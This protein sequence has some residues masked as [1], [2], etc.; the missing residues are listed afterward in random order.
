MLFLK[1]TGTRGTRLP[2]IR[3]SAARIAFVSPRVL[4]CP[5]IPEFLIAKLDDPGLQADLAAEFFIADTQPVAM[6]L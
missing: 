4:S 2:A 1:K 6:S 5:R 3:A